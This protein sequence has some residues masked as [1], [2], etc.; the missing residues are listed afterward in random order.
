M[1]IDRKNIDTV[2]ANPKTVAFKSQVVAFIPDFDQA[3]KQRIKPESLTRPQRDNHVG[4]INRITQTVY[5]ADRRNHN[6]IPPL[7]QG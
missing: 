7:K 3:A 6:H 1:G 2:A 4:I 5:A